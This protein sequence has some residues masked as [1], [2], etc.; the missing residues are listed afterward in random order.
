MARY[1]ENSGNLG[2]ARPKTANCIPKRT[3]NL[4]QQVMSID[5]Y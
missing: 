5:V 3:A 4:W 2:S 1:E